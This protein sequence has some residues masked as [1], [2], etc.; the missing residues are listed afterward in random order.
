MAVKRMIITLSEED[1]QWLAGYSH[2]HRISVAEAVRKGI[3]K[4][5]EDEKNQ[6]YREL[7]SLTSG[8]WKK[9]EGLE[10]QRKLRS[11]WDSR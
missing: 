6:T 4:L 8:I 1:K 10:Y 3:N 2:A 7:I 11:E 5:K 9:G